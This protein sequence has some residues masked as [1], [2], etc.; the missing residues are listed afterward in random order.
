M[1]RRRRMKVATEYEHGAGI[2]LLLMSQHSA[3]PTCA[4]LNP[5]CSVRFLYSLLRLASLNTSPSCAASMFGIA[6]PAVSEPLYST[7]DA[8]TH[9][10]GQVAGSMYTKLRRHAKNS[11]YSFSPGS[12]AQHA[13][14]GRK[15][16]DKDQHNVNTRCAETIDTCR[17][18][19]PGRYSFMDATVTRSEDSSLQK[20][21]LVSRQADVLRN[22]TTE[23]YH[24]KRF[25]AVANALIQT[26]HDRSSQSLM[27]LKLRLGFSMTPTN[28]GSRPSNKSPL[29]LLSLLR[30]GN[31]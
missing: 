17:P 8:R 3:R 9:L 4:P 14:Q 30:L 22:Q 12:L 25:S 19:E 5:V 1:E 23:G 20:H 16:V 31:S 15:A 2:V 7:H 28:V 13:G 6:S 24:L 11:G 27:T 29:S 26:R 18:S 21:S 10:H